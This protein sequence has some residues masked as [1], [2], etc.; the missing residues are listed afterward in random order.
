MKETFINECK[1]IQQNCTYTAEAHHHLAIWNRALAYAFQ[2]IPAIV[3]AV[4]S[5]LV[6]AN[7]KPDSWL[8]ATVIASVISAVATIIDPNKKYQDHLNAAKNFTI[9]KHDARFLYDATSNNLSDESFFIA[10]ENLHEKYNELVRMTPPTGGMSFG[11]ARKL[12]GAGIHEP[13]RDSDGKI[14]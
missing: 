3:A 4:T 8:W 2:I 7:V 11:K 13:D 1:Q 6:V 10:V 12:V 9:L 14:K 5:G